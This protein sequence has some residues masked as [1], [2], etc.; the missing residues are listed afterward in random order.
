MA[1]SRYRV[2]VGTLFAARRASLSFFSS[3]S[4]MKYQLIHAEAISSI[5]RCP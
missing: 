1:A 3:S 2:L 5:V 4:D